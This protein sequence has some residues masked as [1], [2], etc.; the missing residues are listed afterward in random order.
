MSRRILLT[1][2]LVVLLG[3]LPLRAQETTSLEFAV[4]ALGEL[5]SPDDSA[6]YTFDALADAPTSLLL[7]NTSGALDPVLTVVNAAT[8]ETVIA[9]DDFAYPDTTDAILQAFTIPRSG[10]YEVRVS[11]F[12]ETTGSY[13]LTLLPGYAALAAYDTFDSSS[14]WS[15]L[16]SSTEISSD[17]GALTLSLNGVDARGV[18][19]SDELPALA[20]FYAEVRI[21]EISG[22]NAWRAGL[23]LR[24]QDGGYYGVSIN[25]D[26]L[27]RFVAANRENERIIRDWASHPA[28][29][30]GETRFT[31]GV[32]ANRDGFE[33]F[34]N[35]Q[36]IGQVRDTA[37]SEAGGIGLLIGTANA[38]GSE[39]RVRF[40][41]LTIT[42]PLTIDGEVPVPQ[43]I[44]D[45]TPSQIALTLERQHIIPPGGEFGLNVSESFRDSRVP[46]V[47]LQPLASGSTFSAFVLGTTTTIEQTGGTGVSGC[48]LALRSTDQGYTV[49]YVD[50]SGAYGVAERSGD[51]FEAGIYGEDA[52]LND[53]SSH[54]LIVV[55]GEDNLLYF[56]NG[57][58]AGQMPITPLAG[59]VGNA[60]VN[61]DP[62][63]T[64]CRFR[65]TWLWRWNGGG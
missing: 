40:D 14:D 4:P 49:A 48:G 52:V 62:V 46:G 61:F 64:T 33:I 34:Y 3:G 1:A 5:E 15:P 42:Q 27:W 18:A 37:I 7:E 17:D 30:P 59:E 58:F 54:D 65:D 6:V 63:S 20:D 50:S 35:G 10:T 31:L 16:A 13:R 38:I 29:R 32:L 12:G 53:A 51:Q 22:R 8:G 2:L 41:T 28:I 55:A 21:D 24:E 36:V 11:G 60:L 47:S 56:I 19:L 39:T 26:G 25:A 9:N 23:A 45:G 44:V 43:Q 57:M